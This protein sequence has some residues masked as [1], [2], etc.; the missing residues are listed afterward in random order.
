MATASEKAVTIRSTR[1]QLVA[2]NG[3]VRSVFD[4]FLHAAQ[5]DALN[6]FLR[7]FPEAAAR[8]AETVQAHIRQGTAGPLAGT[9]LAIKDNEFSIFNIVN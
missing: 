4:A 8:Q 5:N 3:D 2:G 9:I 1:E 6:A 7:L